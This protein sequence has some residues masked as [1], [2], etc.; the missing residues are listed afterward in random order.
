MDLSKFNN[1]DFD[2]GASRVK[3]AIWTVAKCLF[4]AHSLPVPSRWKRVLLRAFG[5][6]IGQGVIIR[7]RV[8]ISF[9]WRLRIGDHAWLG[10]DV[11]IL[12]LAVVE[13]GRNACIS[14]RAFLCTGSHQFD[15]PHFDLFTEPIRIGES[16]WVCAQSFIGPGVTIGAGSRCLPGSVVV[17]DVESGSTVAGVPARPLRS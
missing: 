1:A 9:P 17:K 6:E 2:R 7:S 16:V 12:S 15:S 14:Q 8:D 4:F 5:A 3:E 11:C 13:V 10:S